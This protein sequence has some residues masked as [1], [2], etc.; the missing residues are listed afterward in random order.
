MRFLKTL[1]ESNSAPNIM[2]LSTVKPLVRMKPMINAY[3]G[4]FAAM[5]KSLPISEM[6][7]RIDFAHARFHL[8]AA[9]GSP[10]PEFD[11]NGLKFWL[12]NFRKG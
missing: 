9:W 12:W 5:D 3:E 2:R 1:I 4:G 6:L 11:R 8:L 7:K 10:R